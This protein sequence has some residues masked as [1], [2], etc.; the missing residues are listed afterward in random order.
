M[1]V[2]RWA[3]HLDALASRRPLRWPRLLFVWFCVLGARRL[4]LVFWSC[5]R[6]AYGHLRSPQR[7]LVFTSVGSC[8]CCTA[9][10][11]AWLCASW[12]WPRSACRR[13]HPVARCP[14]RGVRRSPGPCRGVCWLPVSKSSSAARRHG[15]AI[16]AHGLAAVAGAG[17]RRRAGHELVILSAEYSVGT[18][19]DDVLGV[20]VGVEV[21]AWP[22]CTASV[23][24]SRTADFS[25]LR[26]GVV[27]GRARACAPARQRR[28][29]SALRPWA[30]ANC[31]GRDQAGLPA[32][33]P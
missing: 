12:A 19:V 20:L 4:F 9:S 5:G 13:R 8:C 31:H 6:G 14:G 11:H 15:R 18:V 23:S 25:A 33:I 21:V 22:T 17:R 26:P 29:C 28:N 10:L 24:A 27:G 2:V 30:C 16:V 3:H 7:T 1:R 32:T